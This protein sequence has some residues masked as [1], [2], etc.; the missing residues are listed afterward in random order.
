MDISALQAFLAVAETS[1]FSLAAEKLFLTQPAVSKRIAALEQELGTA[2]FDR[3]GR[4]IGLTEAGRALLPRARRILDELE[5][6]R[7]A[8]ANLS[9]RIAGRLSFATSHHIGLHRLP[10]VLREFHQRYPEVELD[11]QFMDSEAA[12]QAVLHGEL[13]LGIVTLPTLTPPNLETRLLWNDPLAVVVATGH[14]L[15]TGKNTA[16]AELAQWP[17]ILPAQGTYT[18]EI[19]EATFARAGLVPQVSMATNYLE[20]IKML[21]AV[22]LGWSV[23]PHT[24]L[25]GEVQAL[26]LRG[27]SPQRSLGVVYH[28]ARSRS[29][30]AEAL[31]AVA[32]RL[33]G[34]NVDDH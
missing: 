29:N 33:A 17:A 20:T 14:P 16:V 15:A 11:I 3:I 25:D 8:I 24:M 30:A 10:P 4:Q 6:S 23:L 5:D 32:T 19:V 12:C 21:V 26:Q 9:G 7:R 13:E 27:F 31:I 2:L 22:G 18:R 1:S 34:E 28:R